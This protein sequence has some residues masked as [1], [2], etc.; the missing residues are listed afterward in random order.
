MKFSNIPL[1]QTITQLCLAKEIKHIVICPG[2]RNAPLTIAFSE[3]ENFSVFSIVDERCA[4]FFALGIAQQTKHPVAVI[5]TSGSAVLN[6]YPAIAEAFYSDIPLVVISADRPKN[7]IDIGDGQT[8]RQ[9]NVFAN[10]I[11]Y[12]ANLVIGQDH[13]H[14]LYNETQ[15]NIALN[16]A[17]EIKGPVHINAP[18]EEPLYGM[19]EDL[20]VRPQHVPANHAPKKIEED[21][22]EFVTVWNNA[23]RKLILV[24]V[25]HPN[26]IEQK[27]LHVLA[28]DA[29]VLV[30]TE[31]TSNLH[32]ESFVSSIDSLIDGLSEE[33]LKNLQPEILLTFGGMVISKKIKNFL[34]RYQPEH[35]WHIDEKKA[36]DT[37]FCLTKY[38][39]V[40]PQ[41]FFSAFLPFTEKLKSEYQ[42]NFIEIKNCKQVK[43]NSFLQT[44][45]L[46]DL[47][48]FD[49]LLKSL[50]KNSMLQLSNSA[51]IRYAQLFLISPTISVF[52]NRGTS[53]IDGSTSTAI[54]AAYASKT[55]TTFITGDLSFFYDSNALWN[56]YIPNN[57]RILLINNN[58]G[59]IFRILQGNKDIQNFETFFE[60]THALTAKQLCKM[61][62]I[63]YQCASNEEEIHQNIKS[64]YLESNRPILLEI[65]TPRKENDTILLDYFRNLK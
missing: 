37:Y 8:I 14:Q 23:K 30:F 48:V 42:S 12:S 11:L 17:I 52:C 57:F 65:L 28:N 51:T 63:T 33:D 64:F 50:P 18:F 53:G 1:A 45:G 24:G 49:V 10:H 19:V 38:F 3:N 5:C 15:I 16:T 26:S 43:H 21:L 34:R 56:N 35:H 47:K 54:G 29:S 6:F 60:T 62:S 22:S 27:W 4:A 31:T 55:R 39:E 59:G 44:I 2:S 41:T 36:Y 46:S 13:D 32:Q 20:Q 58:G 25:L 7:F 40:S 9:E 61:Y